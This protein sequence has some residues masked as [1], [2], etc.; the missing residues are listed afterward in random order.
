L[1]LIAFLVA[2]TILSLVFI[3]FV[4]KWLRKGPN[5]EALPPAGHARG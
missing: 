4:A 5:L 1:S 2:Y 3:A